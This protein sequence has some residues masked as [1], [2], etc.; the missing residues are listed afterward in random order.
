MESKILPQ[1]SIIIVTHKGRESLLTEC[2]Q[3]LSISLENSL[4]CQKIKVILFHNGRENNKLNTIGD[5]LNLTFHELFSPNNLYPGEARNKCIQFSDG[6]YIL[7]LD[8][9]ISIPLNYF[10]HALDKICNHPLDV[11]GGPDTFKENESSFEKIFSQALKSPLTFGHTVL[12]HNPKKSSIDNQSKLQKGHEGNLILCHLWFKRSL[13]TDDGWS[14][15]QRLFRNEENLL[16][17]RLGKSNAKIYYDAELFV[18]HQRKHNVKAIFQTYFKSGFY[19]VKSNLLYPRSFNLYYFF[20]LV[21][22]LTFLSPVLRVL[23]LLYLALLFI[24]SFYHSFKYLKLNTFITLFLLK[25]IILISY[26]IG[27]FSSLVVF[28]KDLLFS[29]LD[30]KGKYLSKN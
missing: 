12:R 21:I 16:L 28:A 18:H 4:V 1:F 3:S 17:W 25:V 22:V 19:R 15:D 7:F 27:N 9:D 23:G 24:E 30:I 10:N 14:F 20:P 5:Y 8:D 6:E 11:Y 29:F 13:F 2:L 26:V